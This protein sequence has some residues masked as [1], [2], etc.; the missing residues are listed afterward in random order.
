MRQPERLLWEAIPVPS[1]T[2]EPE[3]NVTDV[4]YIRLYSHVTFTRIEN[5]DMKGEV[6]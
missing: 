2:P 4:D 1:N 3:N 5:K 6:V